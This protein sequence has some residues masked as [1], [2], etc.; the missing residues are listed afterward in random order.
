MSL[1]KPL[2]R[3]VPG[4][5]LVLASASPRR[6]QFIEE[7][8][9]P[10]TL[11]CPHGVEPKP[12]QGES[13]VTYACRAARTKAHA[14]QAS[15]SLAERPRSLILA[16]DT[17]VTLQGDIL[18]KPQDDDYALSMLERLSGR[19]HEVI[20]AVCLL[21]P[22]PNTPSSTQ[23]EKIFYD[24]CHVHFHPWPAAVLTAYAATGEPAD[25]AGAY[26]IQGQ[27]A[28]LVEKIEGSWTTVVGLPVTMLVEM[29]LADGYM[30]AFS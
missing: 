11:A 1:S 16:A 13:P 8:G 6:R 14:A 22:T 4:L 5:D 19:S 29:L 18:G 10:Y 2:F 28:F 26:A 21:L 24:K 15:L 30:E 17:V 3:L 7:L 9:L 20:S 27:G 25:K 12:D 23:S